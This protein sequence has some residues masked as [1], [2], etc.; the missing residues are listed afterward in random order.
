[1]LKRISEADEILTHANM[2]V[3]KWVLSGNGSNVMVTLGGSSESILVDNPGEE[4]ML[5]ILWDPSKD[6]FKFVVRINLSPLK[7]KSRLDA[8]LSQEEL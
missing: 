1:M 3:K 2:H 4:R 5:G 8:D 7:N 6:V